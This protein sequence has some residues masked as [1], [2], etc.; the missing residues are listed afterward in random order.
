MS[1]ILNYYDTQNNR[2]RIYFVK[3]HE[4]VLCESED[5]T[6]K[7]YYTVAWIFQCNGKIRLARL[8]TDLIKDSTMCCYINKEFMAN[9]LSKNPYKIP[10]WATP[11]IITLIDS[12]MLP[13]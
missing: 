13:F 7:C 3:I 8:L 6:Q 1:I 11:K 12:Y 4:Y 9:L 2:D 10:N 5:E